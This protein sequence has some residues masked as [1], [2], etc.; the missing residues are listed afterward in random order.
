[1]N[2]K[3]GAKILQGQLRELPS[4][5]RRRAWHGVYPPLANNPA[6][7]MRNPGESIRRS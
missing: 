2:E 6:I 7:T 1:M 5:E 3:S 4:A